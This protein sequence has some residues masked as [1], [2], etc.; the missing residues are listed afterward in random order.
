M[1][2]WLVFLVGLAGCAGP[3]DGGADT[4]DSDPPVAP[5]TDAPD[6]D[7]SAPTDRL[8]AGGQ[9]AIDP[10]FFPGLGL[11]VWQDPDT[12]RAWLAEVVAE[13]GLWKP[14]DGQGLLLGKAAPMAGTA[15][16]PPTYNGPEWGDSGD[17]IFFTMVDDGGFN[18][19]ARFQRGTGVATRLTGGDGVHRNG[20]IP[21]LRP[22]G[23]RAAMLYFQGA[24]EDL[25]FAWRWIDDTVDHPFAGATSADPTPRWIPGEDAIA[26]LTADE[27]GLA[28]VGRY[29]ITSGLVT[30]LTHDDGYKSDPFFSD[31]PAGGR[32]LTVGVSDTVPDKI[33][34][35]VPT[36]VA[37]YR[38]GTDGW[39]RDVIFGIEDTLGGGP[40]A[41]T[42]LEPF[43][44]EG[45][46][47]VSFVA[48]PGASRALPSQVY[49][50]SADG[51]QI[52]Q[53]TRGTAARGDP[54]VVVQDGH[55]LL[56]YTEHRTG[57]AAKVHVVRDFMP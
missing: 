8:V 51:S 12:S 3:D 49:V 1:R 52:V 9:D 5:D 15:T 44:Y 17:S 35:L 38:E 4:D 37:V 7:V 46:V 42:S 30:Q 41:H 27:A 14:V 28:Q 48:V 16:A 33:N 22:G 11:V 13:T 23:D 34:D 25:T 50:A 53:V 56:Y 32:L 19:I 45:Q 21:Q 20:V 36:R 43:V 29:D 40:Y 18:Q 54:E 47:W 57:G 31:D 39:T 24:L 26:V 55:A 10:E 6:T 2:V